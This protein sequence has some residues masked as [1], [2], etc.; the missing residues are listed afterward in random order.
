M[1]IKPIKSASDHEAALHKIER[2]WGAPQGTAKGDRLHVLMTL[3]DG[4]EK[5]HYPIA[6]PDPLDAIRFR[7]E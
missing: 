6:R 2:R 7:L 1:E 5:A 3:V 4:Y